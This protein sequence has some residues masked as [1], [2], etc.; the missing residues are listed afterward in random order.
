MV[1]RI[2]DPPSNM[3]HACACRCKGRV[4]ASWIPIL[5]KRIATVHLKEWSKESTDFSLA[6]FR[7]LL[8]GTTDWTAVLEAFEKV[9]YTGYLTVEHFKPWRHYPEGLVGQA[10]DA[11]DRILG[12]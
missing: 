3:L 10:S 6:G 1:V 12:R 5:G 7:P 9:G 2:V 8:D 11:L 4:G